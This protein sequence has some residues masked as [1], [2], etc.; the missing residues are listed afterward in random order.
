M[1]RAASPATARTAAARR[2]PA[3]AACA[4]RRWPGSPRVLGHRDY[5]I[6]AL[7]H[8]LSGPLDGRT[9]AEVMPPMG[10][11]SDRWI[12]DVASF[13]RNGF[14]NASSVISEADVARARN[15]TAGREKMWTAEE[16][17]RTLPRAARS[18]HDVAGHGEPQQRGRGRGIRLHALVERRTATGRACGSRS[19]CREPSR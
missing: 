11:S 16:I 7:L 2:C 10:A 4:R 5:V 12:A 19:S 15:E 3:D 13:I 17:E 6:K 8:G 9:Y 1:P 14:G 18:R